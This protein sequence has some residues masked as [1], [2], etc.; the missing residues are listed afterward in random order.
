MDIITNLYMKFHILNLRRTRQDLR[1]SS[2]A[3]QLYKKGL[4]PGK[5]WEKGPP[6]E[7]LWW[8]K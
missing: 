5:F 4:G 8:M 3:L 6:R 1:N 2:E 7:A